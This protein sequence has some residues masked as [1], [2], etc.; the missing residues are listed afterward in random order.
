MDGIAN[1]ISLRI[2]GDGPSIGREHLQ[3]ALLIIVD[4][5]YLGECATLVTVN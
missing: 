3:L 4:G 2:S 1:F 5:I